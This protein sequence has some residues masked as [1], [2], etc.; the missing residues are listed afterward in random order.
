MKRILF[1]IGLFLSV[2]GQAQTFNPTAHIQANDA[3]GFAQP[4]PPDARSMFYDAAHVRYRDYQNTAE[5]NSYLN[6]ATFRTG[7]FPIYIH[8]GGTLGGTGIWS[9]GI[10]QVWFYKDS[11][12]NANLVRWYTDS[13]SVG[14]AFLVANNLS[15][16]VPSTIRTNIGF[17]NVDNTSD[18]TKNAA[19]VTLS[20]KTISGSNNTLINI[21]NSA[22]NNSS[23]GITLGVSGTDVNVSGT[24]A[25]LGGNFTLNVP[26]GGPGVTGKISSTDWNTFNNKQGAITLT[27]AGTSGPATFIGNVLN[28]PQ[29]PAGV[30]GNGSAD[31]IKH[32]F[33]DTSANRNGY[34]LAF[35]STN[36]KWYLSPNGTGTGITGLTGDGTAS[37][38]GIVPFTLATV[39]SNVGT[40]GSASSVA[41]FTTN[42]KGLTTAASSVAIQIGESQVTNLVSDL[43]GKQAQLNGTGFVKASGTTISYDNSTYLT[44]ALTSGNIFVGNGSNVATGVTPSGAWT[45]TNAGLS[46][47]T[48][49]SVNTTNILNNAV[50]LGKVQTSTPNNIAGWDGSGNFASLAPDTLFVKNRVSGTGVQL[51]NISNDTLYLNNLVAGANVTLTKNADSSIT[52]AATP[53]AGGIS[54]LNTLTASTQTFATGTSGTDFN[55]VSATSTHTFNFPNSSASNR[56][57]LTSTDWSTFNGKQGALTLTTTGTSGASTLIGTTLN[58][59]N[60]TSGGGTPGGSNTQVQFNNSGAFGGSAAMTFASGVFNTDTASIHK[61]NA[62]SV[63]FRLQT[64][65]KYRL[66]SLIAIC[67]SY[68]VGTGATIIDSGYL[69]LYRDTAKIQLYNFSLGGTGAFF[70]AQVHDSLV[71]GPDNANMSWVGNMFNDLRVTSGTDQR[72]YNKGAAANSAIFVN[73]F[74]QNYTFASDATSGGSVTRSGT[75][76]LAQNASQYGG[77]SKQGALTTTNGDFITKTFVGT[78]IAAVCIGGDS[79]NF[80]GALVTVQIDGSSVQLVSLNNVAD[81]ATVNGRVDQRIPIAIIVSGLTYGLHTLK[82]INSSSRTLFVDYFAQLTAAGKP[83][84]II[85]HVPQPAIATLTTATVIKANANIDSTAA[86]W[87]AGFPVIVMPFNDFFNFATGGSGDNVHPNNTGYLQL[88]HSVQVA[89]QTNG[90]GTD[91]VIFRDSSSVWQTYKGA[92]NKLVKQTDVWNKGDNWLN[93]QG[94]VLIPD[95]ASY[96][97]NG[98]NMAKGDSTNGNLFLGPGPGLRIIR[99]TTANMTFA[100][101]EAGMYQT[102][103][104]STGFGYRAV[105]GVIAGGNTGTQNTGFGQSTLRDVQTGS[106]NTAVG[107]QACIFCNGS[108]NTIIGANSFTASA[109]TGLRNTFLGA[110]VGAATTSGNRNLF[111]GY[112]TGATNTTGSNNILIGYALDLPSNSIQGYGSLGNYLYMF[113]LLTT[114]GTTVSGG[115]MGVGTIAPAFGFDIARA[116]GLSKDSIPHITQTGAME[117]LVL[118]TTGRQLKRITIPAAGSTTASNG[119]TLTGSNITL[120]GTLTGNT[121]IANGGFTMTHSGTGFESFTSPFGV[122]VATTTDANYTVGSESIVKLAVITADRVATLPTASSF[123]GRYLTLTS[124]NTASFKWTTTPSVIDGNGT[125]LS[126]GYLVNGATYDIYSDGTNWI[127]KSIKYPVSQQVIQGAVN[128]SS[129]SSTT[130]NNG[131]TNVIFD[132]ASAIATY[133]LTL[134]SNPPDGAV[135]KIHFGGTITTGTVVTLLTISPNSGQT[136]VQNPA[137]T[138]GVV[139]PAVVYQ[140]YIATNSW[141]REQ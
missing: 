10:T 33:V 110:T 115:L 14:A 2:Y 43:A 133:T 38:S 23:I 92:A 64:I 65:P 29:Y 69:Q 106:S 54:T 118:D 84:L 56:G 123:I 87:P 12:A 90:W 131:L 26:V 137:V 52:I 113:G 128:I 15:E 4:T 31:S 130:L 88:F 83:S 100:G 97:Q 93:F 120:G 136:L 126:I 86:S 104:S 67:N 36:H 68:G 16:G 141:Y 53:G 91:G 19:A 79:T 60:Y 82:L 5:V 103:N 105:R 63:K 22:L 6:I 71:N 125:G 59:P 49:N 42:A 8:L 66:S 108:D 89:L 11:T 119:L 44:S 135:V 20:N 112:G 57:L 96:R 51:G 132:P 98:Y 40:F 24:P 34:V 75:W 77:K 27:T 46:T 73:H 122:G 129:G 95:A 21:P 62:D 80:G 111:L 37:G 101:V 114:G 45:I 117:M 81:G 85:E 39:N 70:F 116:I 124:T 30:G 138:T 140:Y 76:T 17:G 109:S 55:I 28:I 35:D 94:S 25:S 107:N 58:I 78:N 41:Q 72:T 7:H 50:T 1:F 18:A 134:P 47:L 48:A 99:G 139:G 9:G 61:T 3:I 13:S 74:A 32:L 121:S 102:S 127:F